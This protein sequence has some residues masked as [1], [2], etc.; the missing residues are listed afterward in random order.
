MEE[1]VARWRIE[2]MGA[3]QEGRREG[4]RR[5]GFGDAQGDAELEK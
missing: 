5:T 4:R 1:R 3:L 2:R